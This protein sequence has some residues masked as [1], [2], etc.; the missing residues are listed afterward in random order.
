[1]KPLSLAVFSSALSIVAL[2]V[3]A[4]QNADREGISNEQQ[5]AERL[6]T[7][8]LPVA[9]AAATGPNTTQLLQQG[10]QNEAAVEQ[11][12]AGAALGNLVQIVQAGAANLADIGQI[13]AANRTV[14]EQRGAGNRIES[15]LTG[16]GIEA[17]I[18]QRGNQNL[19]QQDL[20]LDNRRYLVEQR[21]NANELVQRESGAAPGPGYEVRMVGNGIRLTIEQGR[22]SP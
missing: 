9:S 19:L 12:Y 22:V 18:R 13:G 7:E 14:V 11:R 10:S 1:M 20:S 4:Q 15:Q 21:G 5:L 6:G 17:E 3:V 16:T 8:R 2:P